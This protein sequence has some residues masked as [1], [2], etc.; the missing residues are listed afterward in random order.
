[1]G[2]TRSQT[3]WLMTCELHRLQPVCE[4]DTKMK[5]LLSGAERGFLGIESLLFQRLYCGATTPTPT[6]A[7]QGG[8]NTFR[9]AQASSSSSAFASFRSGVS[10]PS[11][12]EA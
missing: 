3:S 11:V 2:V 10:K 4:S 5:H 6:R 12:N 1:V 7:H 8:R 9:G